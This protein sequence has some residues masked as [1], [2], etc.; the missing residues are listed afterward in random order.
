[1]QMRN[2]RIG[3]TIFVAGLV[4]LALTGCHHETQAD[5]WGKGSASK[6][7]APRT[8]PEGPS[9]TT[10]PGAGGLPPSSYQAGSEC[11]TLAQG[12]WH[13][14]VLRGDPIAA[15]RARKVPQLVPG[16]HGTPL[17]VREMPTLA[18][19]HD[20]STFADPAK[21]AAAWRAA[22]YQEGVA[23]E[24]ANGDARTVV[25]VVRFRDAGGA[26]AALTAFLEDYCSH[27]L[28]AKALADRSGMVVLRDSHTVREV[29]VA[30]DTMFSTLVCRCFA[31]DDASREAIVEDWAD[32]VYDAT[33][34]PREDRTA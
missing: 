29:F 26:R 22:G 33:T 17:R 9:A 3:T 28:E 32:Q 31:R 19:Y 15:V 8:A 4:G 5:A 24:Y 18:S 25:D 23:A 12:P 13:N 6:A 14:R 1:M 27:A 2:R 20:T 30:G 10:T 34:S 16:A 7:S 11:A 21:V